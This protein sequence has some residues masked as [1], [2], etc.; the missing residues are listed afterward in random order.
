MH[1]W[2]RFVIIKFSHY[3]NTEKYIY[4]P[5]SE[6]VTITI[7]TIATNIGSRPPI[8]ATCYI[9]HENNTPFTRGSIHEAQ[10]VALRTSDATTNSFL[11]FQKCFSRVL[12]RHFNARY[13]KKKFKKTLGQIRKHY[14]N[15][16]NVT[17]I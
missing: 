13:L 4:R 17:K 1:S 2:R 12:D 11:W 9:L 10:S 15:V 3:K 5:A 14:N 7:V 16:K 6:D 8:I